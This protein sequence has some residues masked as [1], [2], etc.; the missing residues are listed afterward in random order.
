MTNKVKSIFAKHWDTLSIEESIKCENVIELTITEKTEGDFIRFLV[1]D[2]KPYGYNE[3]TLTLEYELIQDDVLL[4]KTIE[5]LKELKK[6]YTMIVNTNGV[7]KMFS[8]ATKG[9]K[10][11][12]D[13][14]YH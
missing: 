7:H 2:L 5:A 8:D 11:F 13:T 3:V 1:G 6:Y 10:L 9:K 12:H 14:T 4:N